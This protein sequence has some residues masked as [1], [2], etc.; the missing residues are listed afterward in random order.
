MAV[1]HLVQAVAETRGLGTDAARYW[2]ELLAL[3]APDDR[4][5]RELNGWTGKDI[6][7]AATELQQRGLVIEAR[8]RGAT[9]TRFLPGGWMEV[10]GPGRPMEVWKAPT[11]FCGRTTACTA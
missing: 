9:R 10:S 7:A 3:T 1:P 6:D 2:L 11:T 8:R 4:L 5:I